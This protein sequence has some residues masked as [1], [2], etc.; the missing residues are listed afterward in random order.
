M[1]AKSQAASPRAMSEAAVWR[2]RSRG[3]S[4]PLH[5]L[6]FLETFCLRILLTSSFSPF[7]VPDV[8]IEAFR[9]MALK[10]LIDEAAL[11]EE[12]EVRASLHLAMCL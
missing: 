2:E 4:A 1:E 6:S 8:A 9:W 3:S 7:Q 12:R 11:Q 10:R 5:S